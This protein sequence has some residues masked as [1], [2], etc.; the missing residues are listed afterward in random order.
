MPARNLLER[1]GLK[2]GHVVPGGIGGRQTGPARLGFVPGRSLGSGRE[3]RGTGRVG[4]PVFPVRVL[5]DERRDQ[6]PEG[7]H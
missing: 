5:N 1:R 4:W 6:I 3:P 7:L 2:S